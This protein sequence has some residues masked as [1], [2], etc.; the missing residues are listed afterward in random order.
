MGSGKDQRKN[1]I[2]VPGF[3]LSFL[4][5]IIACYISFFS[6]SSIAIVRPVIFLVASFF[7]LVPFK[8][9]PSIKTLQKITGFYLI[10][11]LVNQSEGQYFQISF[12]PV[13]ASIPFGSAILLLCATGFLAGKVEP[14]ERVTCSYAKEIAGG[15]LLAGAVITGHMLLL[16]P[17][18]RKFYGYG[19]ER[20]WGVLGSLCLY[21]LVFIFLW[22]VLEKRRFRQGIGLVFA[23]FYMAM[24]FAKRGL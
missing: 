16:W 3:Y 2:E 20:N 8:P 21:L 18:L 12:L 1:L 6:K 13:K 4:A 17:M 5:V 19:Y 10:A 15:W 11:I 14:G 7:M 24:I 9:K 23:V 22:A